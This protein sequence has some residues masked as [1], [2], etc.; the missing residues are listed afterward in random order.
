MSYV[1]DTV[2]G[3]EDAEINKIKLPEGHNFVCLIY[4]CVSTS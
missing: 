2:L 3:N 4:C 1:S